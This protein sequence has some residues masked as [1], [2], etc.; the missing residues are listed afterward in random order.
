MVNARAWIVVGLGL[1]FVAAAHLSL[2]NHG[3]ELSNVL[4]GF[5][6]AVLG[7]SMMHGRAMIGW[8]A[9]WF[10]VWMIVSAFI[11]TLVEGNG[12]HINNI[13]FGLSIALTGFEATRRRKEAL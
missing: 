5:V 8:I 6:V 2:G 3:Q 4:V 11:P 1:W 9:G 10:G 7:F 12:L 13:V